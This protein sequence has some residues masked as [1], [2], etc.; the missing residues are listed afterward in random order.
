ME[1]REMNYSRFINAVS[2]A[3]RTSPIRALTDLQLKAPPS[4]IS[5]ATGMP[6]PNTFPFLGVSVETRPL[7]REKLPGP[8][9]LNFDTKT[10]ARML[11]YSPTDGIPELIDWFKQLQT[12]VHNP[13]T[14][15]FES[16]DTEMTVCIT[17]GSQEA[18]SKVFEMLIT[19]GDYVLMD[20]PTYP[21]T[22]IAVEPLGARVLSVASDA[23][24]M[25]PA[26]L[27]RVLSPWSPADAR[28]PASGIPRV[29]CTVPN[30]GNPTGAS[31]ST[32]RKREIYRIAQEYD[33]LIIED[34]P[35]FYLQFKKPWSESFLSMDV[36]GRVIRTDSFSKIISSGLRLGFLTGPKKLVNRVI[37]HMQ[38]STM[39]TSTFSQI[40]VYKLLEQ[41]GIDGFLDHVD[42]VVE[43]YRS[44]KDAMVSSAEKWLTGLAEWDS[45]QA[46]M[47]L[48]IKLLGVENSRDLIMKK[49]L[50]KEVLFVPGADFYPGLDAVSSHLRASFSITSPKLIDTGLQRLAELVRDEVQQELAFSTKWR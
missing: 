13:P 17:T 46:G 1:R 7:H 40:L 37:L 48:W 34:D 10:V 24:G 33:L 15:K 6:N 3:R 29:L 9:R 31:L 47:F 16:A 32:D 26:D 30:G 2:A 8:S 4:L 5:L 11:Q 23:Q 45:P 28:V 27:R 14:R 41:W 44:Q 12:R 38:T 35:Y 42:S 18:I 22:L 49:A 25:I 39:H 21:G 20:T 36:D 50:A 43:F 19:R